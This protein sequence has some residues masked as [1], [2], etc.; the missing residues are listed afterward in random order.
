MNFVTVVLLGC[1]F[2]LLGVNRVKNIKRSTLALY[3]AVQF[4]ILTKNNIRFS[5]MD[6]EGLVESGKKENY[7][8]LE[9]NEGVFLCSSASEKAKREFNSFVS[10]IG[11]TDEEGQLMLCDEYIEKFK[12]LYNENLKSE[13]GKI[14]VSTAISVLSV[15]CVFLLGGS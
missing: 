8:Y 10:K 2:I 9:F 15:V 4:I 6:Y 5:S 1:S 11:T 14:S 12:I 13:K 3:E 7:S